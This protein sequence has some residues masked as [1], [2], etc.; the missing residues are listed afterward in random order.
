MRG[1][2]LFVPAALAGALALALSCTL[3]GMATLPRSLAAQR[4][5][6]MERWR[7]HAPQH[8]RVVVQVGF[9]GRTCLQEIEVRGEWKST[10]H[11]TC[12][13]SWL[14]TLSI[15]RLFELGERLERPAEC[16]PSSR[17]CICHRVRVGA[18]EYDQDLGFPGSITWR[19]ELRPNWQH[20]DYLLRLW[21]SRALPNCSSPHRALR[22][23]VISLTPLP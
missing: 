5:A 20:P 8:Y 18:I 6:S 19:R 2:R 3:M 12:G 11:D 16:F 17:S 10:L 21:E 1:K 9:A 22:L 23:T 14:S 4:L 15:P 7:A 13:S